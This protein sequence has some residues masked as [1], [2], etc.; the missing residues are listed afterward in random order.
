MEKAPD[1]AHRIYMYPAGRIDGRMSE[2][3][4][5]GDG[6][7]RERTVN[8]EVFEKLGAELLEAAQPDGVIVMDEIGYMEIGA[9]RFC[10]DVL[11]A[12]DGDIPV[13]ATI[14]ETERGVEYMDRIRKHPKVKLYNLT[15]DRFDA[16]YTEV[17]P[18]VK[19]WNHRSVQ[20]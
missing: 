9:E 7:T 5:I 14:K 2:E 4:H 16:I 19:S 17:L 12:F 3:N 10:R 13:L 15:R 8:L 1:G 6:N 18:T 11:N 20:T